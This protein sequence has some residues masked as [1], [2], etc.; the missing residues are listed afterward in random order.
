MKPD[1]QKWALTGVLPLTSGKRTP[2]VTILGA[3][4]SFFNDLLG[5][6]GGPQVP[7]AP[8][9]SIGVRRPLPFKGRARVGMGFVR[10]G[11]SFLYCI[12]AALKNS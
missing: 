10:G 5:D 9:V 8:L 6:L 1:S 3:R 2:D 12:S 7:V 11:S 4:E